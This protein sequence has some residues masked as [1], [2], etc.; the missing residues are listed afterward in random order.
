[1]KTAFH[2]N[3]ISL[4]FTGESTVHLVTGY[5]NYILPQCSTWAEILEF[6]QETE[7]LKIDIKT[8]QWNVEPKPVKVTAYNKQTKLPKEFDDKTLVDDEHTLL[9]PLPYSDW[10][11]DQW[12][13]DEQA[14]YQ[15]EVLEVSNKRQS[16]YQVMVDPLNKEAAMIRRIDGDE[17]KA[18]A[19]EA[20][21]DA[22]YV[23]IREDNPWPVPVEI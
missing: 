3:P 14:K 5:N 20:Q 10:D 13:V 16:R 18:S 4:L 15:A 19:H 8:L 23:K 21:A 7:Q 1:M 22:A 12:I 11:N 2:Y 17:A 9:E 6:D